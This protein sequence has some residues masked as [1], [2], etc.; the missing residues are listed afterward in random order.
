MKH[1]EQI[2]KP[3]QLIADSLHGQYQWLYMEALQSF[4]RYLSFAK[5][6]REEGKRGPAAYWL[7]EANKAYK[8]V[9]TNK[10]SMTFYANYN[11]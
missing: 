2:V 5:T 9:K 3:E 10:R 8:R 6:D 1:F 11:C 7:T 4:Q